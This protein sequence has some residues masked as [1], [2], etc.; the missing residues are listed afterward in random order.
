MARRETHV[1]SLATEGQTFSSGT[2]HADPLADEGRI[3][4]VP[5]F[6]QRV[7]RRVQ[8]EGLANVAVVFVATLAA[9]RQSVRAG[10]LYQWGVVDDAAISMQFAKNFATGSGL[11]FNPGERVE[12]YTNFLW[13]IVM[14]V[15]HPIARL[16]HGSF[17]R[18]VVNANLI[19]S[20]IA[21][22]LT[23]VLANRLAMGRHLFV[24][25]ALAVCVID[26]SW[27]TWA[28]MGLEGHLL[29]CCTLG[30]LVTA[31]STSKHRAW[32]TGALLSASMLT[33]PDAALFVLALLGNLFVTS[34][35]VHLRARRSER[36]DGSD[37]MEWPLRELLV[38]T[39][40]F[41]TTYA[42][43]WIWRYNYYGYPFPNTYYVKLGAGKIDA[44]KRGVEYLKTFLEIRDWM[45]ALVL[46]SLLRLRDP[47]TRTLFAYLAA[48]TLYVT[49]VGGDFF[50]GHRFFVAQIPVI[51]LLV[52]SGLLGLWQLHA[53]WSAR[54]VLRWLGVP[55]IA[56]AGVFTTLFVVACGFVFARGEV[57]G[58]I[59]GEVRRFADDLRNTRALMRWLDGA[60][61]PN[62]TIATGLLGHTGLMA[63]MPVIDLFGIID[64][65]VA[66]REVAN[67]GK[68]KAGHEKMMSSTEMLARHPTYV[69]MGYH[70]NVDYWAAGYFL[71]V[72]MPEHIR[73]E[74]IWHLDSLPSTM[75]KVGTRFS[76]DS[77]ESLNSWH[78][79]GNAFHVAKPGAMPKGHAAVI[80]N[81]GSFLTSFVEGV[82]DA[83]QG[84][85]VSPM[86]EIE[87]DLITLRLG[88]GTRAQGVSARLVVDG[89]TVQE[90]SGRSSAALGRVEWD[91]KDL[92]GKL[93][94]L[95]LVDSGTHGWAHLIV[96]EVE[97]WAP[98]R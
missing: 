3:S 5:Q 57:D 9:L 26:N 72:S 71:D 50:P 12:G 16:V 62:A 4:V 91:T 10:Q 49:Y 29:A 52:A 43:Y 31:T 8:A 88:G 45:P 79:E 7:W 6:A 48:H 85:A 96:D 18:V 63:Q 66:H 34:A 93:A 47:V 11:V 87:G 28:I 37:M 19:C 32:A 73:S 40:V 78:V 64:T 33:R 36:T 83:A 95:E 55:R 89:T 67:F 75:H 56:L 54:K 81:Q 1:S 82:G 35:W 60:K 92:R 42:C 58:P 77:P 41:S 84:K 14:S 25:A 46:L 97:Q 80:G 22:W 59:Q 44:W 76:F 61:P 21:L 51:G 17:M 27:T 13:V 94:Q 2:D 86:F 15:C 98:G 74:G 90:R 69:A 65:K 39:I 30:A 20:L 38:T 68:G 70:N 53:T 24:A 23:Y